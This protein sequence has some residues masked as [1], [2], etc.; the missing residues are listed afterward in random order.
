VSSPR[1]NPIETLKKNLQYALDNLAEMARQQAKL[2]QQ[3]AENPE[4][5]GSY[6]VSQ[7]QAMIDQQREESRISRLLCEEALKKRPLIG[8]CF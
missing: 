3:I 7:W 6:Q 2:D 8:G 1:D 4:A 5:A